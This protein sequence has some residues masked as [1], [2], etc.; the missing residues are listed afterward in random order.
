MQIKYADGYAELPSGP[1]LGIDIDEEEAKKHP[2]RPFAETRS[3]LQ[4]PDGSVGD[5]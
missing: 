1:G 4:W 2:A 5:T 3:T